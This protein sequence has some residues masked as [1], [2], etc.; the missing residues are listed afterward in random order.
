MSKIQATK[1]RRRKVQKKIE[2]KPE[3]MENQG[4]I[5]RTLAQG[6]RQN[7]KV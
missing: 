7:C 3:D 1:G 4:R 5:Q 6:H 2:D